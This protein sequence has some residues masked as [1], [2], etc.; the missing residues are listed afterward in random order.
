MK[1][2]INI[3]ENLNDITLEQ[4]QRFLKIEEPANEDLLSIFLNLNKEQINKIK[5]SEI[6]K[7]IT[8]INSLFEVKQNFINRFVL[9]GQEFGFI[10]NLDEITYG[11]NADVTSY[12]N[13]WEKMH[14]AM[15]V[16]YRPIKQKQGKKY[17]I[18]EYEG[19]IK[20]SELMKSMP[21]SVVM[22]SM[23]FF[24]NLTKELLK[25]TP[26][27]LEK[28][29]QMEQMTGQISVE[30]GQNTLKLIA[31]LKE[32]LEDLTKLQSYRYINV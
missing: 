14:K 4:Y 25:A 29:I 13:D 11:E 10:P 7:L 1:V 22:G 28:Q 20:Y 15:A 30:S 26:N 8:H 3:P 21:L 24:Y 17:L 32:T 31:S 6:D 5:A 2:E 23:V 18:E 12:I 9:N 27:Y 19:T 16:L